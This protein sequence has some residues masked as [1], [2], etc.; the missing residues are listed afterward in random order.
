MP[1]KLLVVEPLAPLKL[2]LTYE[3]GEVKIFDVA[4]YAN[5]SWYGEL[6][7]ARYFQTVRLLPDGAGIQWG[8]GQDLAPH[9]LYERSVPV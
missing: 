8:N 3:T 6:R 7:D 4:P 9:E 5:G 1:P 2:R